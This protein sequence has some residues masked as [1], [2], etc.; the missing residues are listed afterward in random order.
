MHMF[1][2]DDAMRKLWVTMLRDFRVTFGPD[3]GH[4]P[5]GSLLQGDVK[6]FRNFRWPGRSRVQ[7]YLFKAEYQLENLFKRY[8]FREDAYTDDELLAMSEKKFL[9]TQVRLNQPLQISEL[10]LRVLQ[11]AR[12][13]AREILGEYAEEEHLALCRFGKRACVGSPYQRS[14]LDQKVENI[15]G[16]TEHIRWL[17]T[18]LLPSDPLLRDVFGGSD[19]VIKSRIRICDTLK[20]TFV[21]KSYKALRCIMPDTLVG[22]LYTSGLGRYIQKRLAESGLDITSLQMKHRRLARAYSVT[23]EC[24]TA[25]LSAASDSI[26]TGLLRWVLPN[27]WCHKLLYGRIPYVQVGDTRIRMN[28]VITMGLGHTFPLQTLVFYCLLK[29]IG[30]LAKVPVRKISVYGDDLIYPSRMHKYVVHIFEK[31]NLLLNEDKT[32]VQDFFRESCGGDYCRGCDVRPFQ[33]EGGHS[34]L[35][36]RAYGAFLYRV[37]NGLHRRWE[38]EDLP[39]TFEWL[40]AEIALSQEGVLQVPP[41]FPDEAG[42]KVDKPVSRYLF[43]PVI[44]DLVKQRWV[45]QYLHRN[46]DNRV[47]LTQLPYYWERLREKRDPEI[48]QSWDDV[49]DSPVLQWIKARK[50]PLW[51]EKPVYQW[52]NPWDKVYRGRQRRLLPCVARKGSARLV[53]QTGSTSSWI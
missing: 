13:H 53:S 46:C 27:T 50:P 6:S 26:V 3:Y 4:R 8:R 5:A 32:Y 42:I 36:R 39:H 52:S 16:S 2:T 18:K 35:S 43:V 45:F 28:T 33:P 38:L 19:E 10:V 41:S 21:P 11:R 9:D 37:Y 34:L 47:V 20:L 22:T 30:E 1:N 49:A 7:P 14:Y 23:R 29:A 12:V 48:S 44:W 15:T 51:L 40:E 31:L 24:A 25:D 17:L